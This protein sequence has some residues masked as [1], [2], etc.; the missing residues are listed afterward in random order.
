MRNGWKIDNG[1]VTTEGR[2]AAVG[3]AGPGS[4]TGRVVATGADEQ[5]RIA[6]A[7]SGAKA[8]VTLA[9]RRGVS[10]GLRLQP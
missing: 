1:E 2:K 7:E 3:D 5:D 6:D 9:E 10:N 4:S 8:T